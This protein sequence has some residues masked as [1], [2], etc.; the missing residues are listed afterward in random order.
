MRLDRRP[1]NPAYVLL[2]GLAEIETRRISP[3]SPPGARRYTEPELASSPA[4]ARL[5]A[6][7]TLKAILGLRLEPGGSS[8]SRANDSGVGNAASA[9]TLG[10]GKVSMRSSGSPK[11]VR[12]GRFS[13]GLPL[14]AGSL[15]PGFPISLALPADGSDRP[16]RLGFRG[17][18]PVTVCGPRIG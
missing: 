9:V 5:E 6:D 17:H 16:W 3:R 12:L 7:R 1:V 8:V 10:A 13:D 15:R 14:V 4:D 18:G 11:E 2:L